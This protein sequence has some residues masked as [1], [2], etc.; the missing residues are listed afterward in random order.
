MRRVSFCLLLSFLM[1]GPQSYGADKKKG[2]KV[3]YRKTQEVNFDGADIDG[4]VR[5][6]DGAYLLQKR[7]VQFMPLYKLNNKF[8][9]NIM[10]SVEYL[11]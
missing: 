7:G 6:P 4:Q 8:E 3:E 10:E 5:T 1:F 2:K 11:E 9:L